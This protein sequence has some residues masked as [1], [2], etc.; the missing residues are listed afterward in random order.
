MRLLVLNPNSTAAMTEAIAEAARLAAGPHSE[1]TA[2]NPPDTP[3]AIQG[4]ADGAAALPG[5]IRLFDETVARAP[6]FDAVIIA[7]FDDVGLAEI[8][9]RSPVPVIGIGEAAFH[10]ATLLGPRFSVVTTLE[11]SIPV[12]EA[13]IAAYGFSRH[14]ARV[15]AAG[16]PVLTVG[17][18]DHG[19][20]LIAAEARRAADE[21]DCAAIVLGCAAMASLARTM[22]DEIGLPVIDGV[23]AAVRLAAAVVPLRGEI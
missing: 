4:A 3:P 7:C 23:A 5:L 9:A 15:R 19:E 21:D 17:G 14:C 20:A 8:R 16:V 18:S 2:L 12:I 11:I 22:S 13:N 10:V 6:G 1:I